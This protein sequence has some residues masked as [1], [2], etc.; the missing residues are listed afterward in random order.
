MKWDRTKYLLDETQPDILGL[1][2][3]N[4]VIMQM[5]HEN[6]PQEVIGRWQTHDIC[7]FSWMRNKENMTTYEVGGTG[8]IMSR[9]GSTWYSHHM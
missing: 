8:I 7:R 6:K 9:K 2:E 3:H 5:K 1:S 4:R